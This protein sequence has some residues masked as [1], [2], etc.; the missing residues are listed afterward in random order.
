MSELYD[1]ATQRNVLSLLRHRRRHRLLHLRRQIQRA[2]PLMPQLRAA[3]IAERA[4]CHLIAKK[5]SCVRARS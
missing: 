5:T 4:G 1:R 2:D 3:L